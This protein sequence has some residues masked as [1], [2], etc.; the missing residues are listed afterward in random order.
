MR[1]KENVGRIS[2]NGRWSPLTCG[3]LA[4]LLAELGYDADTRGIAAAVNG[5][6]VPRAAW[7]GH[8]LREEDRIEIVGAAQGG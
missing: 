3:S 7:G 6:V 1:A 8:T 5:T 4:E 2:V